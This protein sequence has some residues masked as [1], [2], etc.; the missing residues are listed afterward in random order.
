[1]NILTRQD[2]K[3]GKIFV[4]IILTEKEVAKLIEGK[5]IKGES[6][7]VALQIVGYGD[8]SAEG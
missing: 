1:M 8:E 5:L 4:D 6:P 2:V 3:T 7:Q